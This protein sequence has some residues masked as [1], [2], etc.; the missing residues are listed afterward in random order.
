M[1]NG[2]QEA[3]AE[4]GHESSDE[5]GNNY[6]ELEAAAEIVARAYR[7]HLEAGNFPNGERPPDIWEYLASINQRARRVTNRDSDPADRENHLTRHLS[8]GTDVG[9]RSDASSV[10]DL[11]DH[12]PGNVHY[13]TVMNA[14]DHLQ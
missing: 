14:D 12:E 10:T 4:I 13:S 7:H 8:G 5:P 2:G 1:R 11:A 9:C 3:E 6:D